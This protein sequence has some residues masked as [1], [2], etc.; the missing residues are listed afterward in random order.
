MIGRGAFAIFVGIVLLAVA[1][2]AWWFLFLVRVSGE[3]RHLVMFAS[4]GAF[5]MLALL[6]GV[7]LMYRTIAEQVR[8][9]ALRATFLS[10]VTHE[11]KS[12][13][14]AIRLFLE[15]LAEG[16]VD[17]ARRG[18]LVRKMLLDVARL[19]R[20]VGDLLRAGQ[21]EAG[22]L[23]PA[24]EE[25]DLAAIAREAAQ[26]ARPRLGPDD[27]LEVVAPEGPV[28]AP[29]DSHLVRSAIENLL[30]NAIKYSPPPRAIRIEVAAARGEA[31]V[32]VCDSGPGFD[33]A[34]AARAFEP[35][36]RGGSEETRATRGTGLG[37]FI[38]RGIADAHGGRAW[39]G[40]EGGAGARGGARVGFA[41][42]LAPAP[43][44][45]AAP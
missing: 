29:A 28:R 31:R 9:R 44:R 35:F 38:V 33:A 42:P 26:A 43:R 7:F 24:L 16:R 8:L 25:V 22:A 21:V 18:D 6:A 10:A 2:V 39:V 41:L 3:R 45:R 13:L 12:P 14:A 15:T 4:E 20:L 17:A 19:E 40:P 11:L 5:F 34:T 30:D 27:R 1:Q 23:V 36:A 32:E 37:L